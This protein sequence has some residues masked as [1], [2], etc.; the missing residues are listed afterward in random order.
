MTQ[1]E[2]QGWVIVAILFVT[3]FLIFGSGYDTSGLFFP[4]LL[5]HFGWTHTKTSV[6]TAAL[7]LTAGFSAPL[8]GWLVDRVE[9]RIVM[10]AG[11]LA[12]GL[13]FFMASRADSFPPMLIA[14]FVLGI[15]IGGATLLPAALVIANWFGAR[16][17]LAM[18][19]AL[20]G[21]SLGGAGMTLVGNYA[22]QHFGGWRAG[23][24][25][26]GAPMI[27]IV[28]PLL[29]LV[30]RS[31]PPQAEKLTVSQAA[32]ALP[33]FELRE[34]LRTRS[35]W[36][37]TSAQFLYSFVASAAGL[38]LISYLMGIGYTGTFAASM[39]SLVYLGTSFGKTVM[40]IMADRVGARIALAANFII[41]A[42]G[43]VLIFGAAH[44]AILV[45]FVITFGF[46]LGAP[47]V[48]GPLLQADSLGLKRFGS[49][50]GFAGIFNTCGAIIGPVATGKI[51]DV[52][53]SYSTAF[54]MMVVMYLVGAAATL[55]CRPL[56]TEQERLRLLAASA[57]PAT[58]S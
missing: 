28:I 4:Q 22:I 58:A 31:R 46:T 41:A 26:L 14:Y 55:A 52:T 48:L 15:G 45:P 56:E 25:A 6:L 49:I 33:G 44:V 8:I 39:M 53:G 47:L 5:K 43:M 27:F 51:F 38:H 35:F 19:I 23:Y 2:R 30:V 29:F 17:G 3:L 18:G 21:T 16:R 13:A 40:G 24:V 37:L 12:A 11:A 36:M 1:R 7:A 50:A 42:V 34:A 9:A 54:E 10:S 20:A 57:A 32:A